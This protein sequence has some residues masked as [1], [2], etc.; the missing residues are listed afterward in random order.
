MPFPTLGTLYAQALERNPGAVAIV[1]G[2][3]EVTY[4][5][6]ARRVGL[7]LALFEA[8]GYGPGHRLGLA[9]HMG[10]DFLTCC[11]A[12][13]IGGYAW[14]DLPPAM[15]LE[16][17]GHRV[18]SG[19]IETV[20]V[21]PH[22][23]GGKAEAVCASFGAD[24]LTTT[25][26]AGYEDLSSLLAGLQPSPIRV[27]PA[28]EFAV[29]GYTGGS[30]GLP[31]A[32][33]FTGE[34]CGALAMTVIASVPFPAKPV[35]VVYRTGHH[36]MQLGLSQT[37]MRGGKVVTI[38]DYD[39]PTMSAQGRKHGANV[40][41]LAT[42]TIYTLADQPDVDWMPGQIQLIFHGGE[43]ISPAR[44]R[45]AI[46]SFG[47]VFVACYGS[48]ETG[49]A[50]V[51]LLPE[52]HDPNRSDRMLSAGRT[53]VGV[54]L[55]IH[56]PDGRPVPTE[57]VGEVA[58]RSPAQMSCYL[59]QSAKTA[60]TMR[61]GW[62]YTGD[63]A[64]MDDEGYVYVV[65]RT[66]FAFESGGKTVYPRII[67]AHISEH[68][69]V[70]I[71]VTVGIADKALVNRTC[72][73]VTLREGAQLQEKELAAFLALRADAPELHHLVILDK[74][75]QIPANLKVDR[76]KVLELV[77]AAISASVDT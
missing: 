22:A 52:D 10:V 37:L 20:I 24:V 64:R 56:G 15:P 66:A 35:T 53:A 36:V 54:E 7:M 32:H 67:D 38:P 76:P 40:L 43:P 49:G 77:L 33:G 31:K 5:D 18:K 3:L 34:A 2:E 25:P 8:R 65:E 50:S 62:V 9:I 47:Q 39:L 72:V 63:V 58:I 71:A 23:F 48:T 14:A 1:E 70:S 46:E 60:E 28:G 11:L 19:D 12:A 29:I 74:I 41:F 59:G 69:A 30:T 68:P 61:N 55:E 44:L 57:E 16:I 17:L 21:Q 4:R 73:A 13:H 27:G 45:N 42:R 26:L 51:L 6:L 75:P